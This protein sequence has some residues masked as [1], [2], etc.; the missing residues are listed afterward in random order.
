MLPSHYWNPFHPSKLNIHSSKKLWLEAPVWR[1]ELRIRR[2][3]NCRVNLIPSP[4]T[5]TCLGCSQ[6]KAKQNKKHWLN[7]LSLGNICAPHR[8]FLGPP[9][10]QALSWMLL[11][12]C[13]RMTITILILQ[14][15]DF[16][17]REMRNL[18]QSY[19]INDGARFVRKLSGLK[20]LPQITDSHQ[21]HIFYKTCR[22]KGDHPLGWVQIKDRVP[23][24]SQHRLMNLT[25]IKG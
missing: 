4:G 7:I 6:N 9:I 13:S 18:V 12:I 3:H 2:C 14:T 16:N 17:H 10:C 24:R 20:Y 25:N 5:S 15:R 1:S 11:F 22:Q 21:M 19:T 23:V 8:Y